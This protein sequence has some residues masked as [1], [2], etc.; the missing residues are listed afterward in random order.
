MIFY[1]SL[2]FLHM[3]FFVYWLGGDLGTFYASWFVRDPKL[4]VEARVTALKIMAG[5]DMA[6][7]IC[8]PLIFGLGIHLGYLETSLAIPKI[9]VVLVWIICLVWL[10][11]VFAVHKN[12]GLP[13]GEKLAKFDMRLRVVLIAAMVLLAL[14]GFATGEI[15]R[16]NWIGIKLLIMAALVAAGL[17]IRVNLVPF[18]PAFGKLVANGPTNDINQEITHSLRGCLPWVYLIWVGL[19][20]NAAIGLNMYN[21]FRG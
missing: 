12:V 8:M 10:W 19:I 21:L 6:P 15:V 2:N 14:Y 3:L 20:V 16:F 13:L 18:A 1:D 4:S 11:L 9:A 5:V 7:R 17:M